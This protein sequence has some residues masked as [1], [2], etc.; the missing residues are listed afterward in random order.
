V[1]NEQTITPLTQ[2][3]KALAAQNQ[4]PTVGVTETIQPP[5]AT[6]QAWMQSEIYNLQNALNAQELGQ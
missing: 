4:I 2:D 5:G 1:Y 6:F 3:I